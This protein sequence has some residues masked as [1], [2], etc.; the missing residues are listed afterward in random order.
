MV[1]L[2]VALRIVS[3]V[4]I[5]PGLEPVVSSYKHGKDLTGSVKGG[6]FCD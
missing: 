1:C 2:L 6:E 5:L 4:Q 3:E